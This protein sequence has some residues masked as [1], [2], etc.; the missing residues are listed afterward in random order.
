[1]SRRGEVMKQYER[2]QKQDERAQ[3]QYERV[4]KQDERAQK[5]DESNILKIHV[6]VVT[7]KSQI[8]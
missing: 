4:Q 8:L 2:V 7:T 6:V 3:K 5:Q 1:M